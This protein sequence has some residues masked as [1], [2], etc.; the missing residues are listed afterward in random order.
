MQNST[1]ESAKAQEQCCAIEHQHYLSVLA[2][3]TLKDIQSLW[4][5][6]SL[7]LPYNVI[8]AAE[9]GM[10]MVRGKTGTGGSTFNAGEMTVTRCVVQRDGII[11]VGY[12]S[13]RSKVKA[14][15]IANIDVYLQDPVHCQ[16]VVNAVIEPLES[17]HKE[18]KAA[19]TAATQR[20]QVDFFTMVRGEA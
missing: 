4:K 20:T 12:T 18:K 2:K 16:N 15:L 6:M 13:G 11:G 5:P 10:M 19:K 17:I 8:K 3:S 1:N 14:E 7:S 9:V